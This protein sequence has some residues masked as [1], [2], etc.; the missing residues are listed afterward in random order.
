MSEKTTSLKNKIESAR[1]DIA[2]M[3]LFEPNLVQKQALITSDK[4]LKDWLEYDF[5]AI[6]EAYKDSY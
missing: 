4:A 1:G 3:L 5:P 6:E 2:Q